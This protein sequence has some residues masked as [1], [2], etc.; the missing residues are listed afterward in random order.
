MKSKLIV[1]VAILIG[2]ASCAPTAHFTD[3]NIKYKHQNNIYD[4][5]NRASRVELPPDVP[6][7]GKSYAINMGVVAHVKVSGKRHNYTT[8]VSTTLNRNGYP[9]QGKPKF[10]RLGMPVYLIISNEVGDGRV[11]YLVVDNKRYYILQFPIN[12]K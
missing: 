2:L 11:D 10:I 4:S 9:I 7:A 6:E 8:W 1:L 5:H 12:E 3:Y